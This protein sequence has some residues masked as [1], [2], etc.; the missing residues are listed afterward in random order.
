MEEINIIN[1][2]L[3]EENNDPIVM[4]DAEGK[5]IV[6]EQIAAIPQGEV[7]Y[8]ILKP[9]DFAT[10]GFSENEAL[11]F[12]VEE[13]DDDMPYLSVEEDDAVIDAVFAVYE[14]L[15]AEEE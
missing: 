5:E 15:L 10:A 6:F 13:P 1:I 9:V 3:D 11:V 14:T 4:M 7:L 2:L 12:R 8:C